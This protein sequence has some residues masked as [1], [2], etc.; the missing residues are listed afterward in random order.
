M[1]PC[2]VMLQLTSLGG[3][4]TSPK[5]MKFP[6]QFICAQNNCASPLEDLSSLSARDFDRP[7]PAPTP[8]SINLASRSIL[9]SISIDHLSTHTT[10]TCSRIWFTSRASFCSRSG[11]LDPLMVYYS[12]LN[13]D[14]KKSSF[15]LPYESKYQIIINPIYAFSANLYFCMY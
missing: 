12:N 7:P 5:R 9:V 3:S 13:L 1:K 2:G 10:R 14:A 8:I 11:T 15:L 4:A 6:A